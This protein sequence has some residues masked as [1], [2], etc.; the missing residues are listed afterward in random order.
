MYNVFHDAMAAEPYDMSLLYYLWYMKSAGGFHRIS[1]V[2]HAAQERKFKGGSQQISK[3]LA[4]ILGEK[5]IIWR[6]ILPEFYLE[7]YVYF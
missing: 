1:D 4:E 6:I 7:I 5:V 2:E 3:K